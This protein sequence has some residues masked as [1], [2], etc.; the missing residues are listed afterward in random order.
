MSLIMSP[1][2]HVACVFVVAFPTCRDLENVSAPLIG[3]P[4]MGCQSVVSL[5][6]LECQSVVS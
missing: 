4:T 1:V 2:L 5:S 3:T 6:V